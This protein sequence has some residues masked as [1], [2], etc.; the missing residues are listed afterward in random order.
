MLLIGQQQQRMGIQQQVAVKYSAPGKRM[1]NK[2][3]RIPI[4]GYTS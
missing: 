1:I 4:A 2:D 3:E